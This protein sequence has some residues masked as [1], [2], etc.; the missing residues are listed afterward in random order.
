MSK[1]K[2]SI[3]AAALMNINIMVGAAIFLGPSMMALKG[4]ELS[5]IGWTVIALVFLPVVWSVIQISKFFPHSKTFYNYS[6]GLNNTTITFIIGWI[7]FLGYLSMAPVQ[8]AGLSEVL[9]TQ[10]KFNFAQN[11]PMLFY[12]IIIGLLAY[13]NMF[14]LK[15]VSRIQNLLTI[16]KLIPIVFVILLIPF[17]WNPNFHLNLATLPSVKYTIP[18]ALFGYWGFESCT[19]VAPHIRGGRKSAVIAMLGSFFCVAL[20]YT[21][22]HLGLLHIMGADKLASDG[23]PAFVY[24]LNIKS[25][26]ILNFL[27]LFISSVITIVYLSSSYGVFIAGS[28]ILYNLAEESYLLFSSHIRKINKYERPRN[29]IILKG[30]IIFLFLALIRDK[31]VLTSI[32]NTGL[33]S[34]FILI[35]VSLLALQIKHKDYRQMI[36]TFFAFI[37]TGILTMYN[38]ANLGSNNIERLQ[39]SLPLA[40]I[41]LIG[42]IMFKLESKRKQRQIIST[43][44]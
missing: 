2:I 22:F 25:P 24:Y 21:I 37:S 18:I 4:Q 3:F 32:C 42:I 28:S 8:I 11:N 31:V 5:F 13:L 34:S 17:Y 27:N 20:I 38:W 36:V 1:N 29:A 16:F 30:L 7:Y 43:S 10:F 26:I 19:N 6:K 44:Q 15:I 33:I 40:V 41:L 23:A 14:S 35:L 39:N 12:A 9:Q